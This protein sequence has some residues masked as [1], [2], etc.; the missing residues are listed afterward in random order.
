M[1]DL[2]VIIPTYNEA[3][4]ISE[5][6][7]SIRRSLDFYNIR[8]EIL[9][10]DDNSPDGT[11]EVARIVGANVIVRT[12]DRGLSQSVVDGFLHAT[13]GILLVIDADGSHPVKCVN[14]LYR[15]IVNGADVA[16]GSRY[17]EGGDIKQWPI[18]RRLVSFGATMLARVLFPE[19]TD[20]VSGIFAIR[21]SVIEGVEL[22]P[23]GYKILTEILGKGNY[24]TVK[25][26]P[27]TFINRKRGKSK[28][29]LQQ[30]VEYAFQILDISVH[31]MTHRNTKVWGEIVRAIQF[32]I[33]G[34]SGIFVNLVS[35]FLLVEFLTLPVMGAAFV[36]IELSIFSNFIFN[37][38]WTFRDKRGLKFGRRLYVFHAVCFIGAVIQYVVLGVLSFIGVWYII[39]SLVG[40]FVAYTWNFIANRRK[41]WG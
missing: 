12:T 7:R 24:L 34:L 25:E 13:S 20:P 6:I 26:V 28:L 37:D 18:Y 21:R 29:G 11:A 15:E 36:A 10:V 41:T 1:P 23:S 22:R 35:L 19:I 32:A 27:Y 9:V 4:N 3:F 8:G 30:I 16:I 38:R 17:L 31:A 2:T 39:A 33:V 14:R 5:T 40:I